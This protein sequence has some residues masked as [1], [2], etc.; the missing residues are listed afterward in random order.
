MVVLATCTA[1][2]VFVTV[3]SFTRIKH[4]TFR[5]WD[6]PRSQ[7]AFLGAV[8]LGFELWRGDLRSPL[9]WL[10]VAATAACLVYQARWIMPYTRV[11]PTQVARSKSIDR[12][13]SLRVLSANVLQTNT[14]VDRFVELVREH[15][16][17]IVVT[18]ETNH[19]WQERLV[20]LLPDYPHRLQAPLENLYGMHVFSK[21]PLEH[22]KILY[23]VEHDKPSMHAVVRLPSGERVDLHCLHPAPP[24]PTENEESTERD[25][26]LLKVANADSNATLP[27]VVTGDLNDVA[28]SKTTR[29]FRRVSRLHDPRLGRGTFATFPARLPISRWPLDH[30]FHSRSFELVDIYTLEH[31]GSDHLPIV[32]EL[33]LASSGTPPP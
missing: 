3:A 1:L 20:P 18:L 21:L 13:R 12:S 29:R 24:A 8:L 9:T 28:W 19:W 25:I 31:W 22:G 10:L 16:P 30:V 4:W 33:T 23:L 26:E 32:F 7:L 17:D 11:F 2:F 5:I 15:E 27:V 14:R 6:F